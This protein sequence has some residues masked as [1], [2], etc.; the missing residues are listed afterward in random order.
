MNLHTIAATQY[1]QRPKDERFESPAALLAAA[2]HD[3]AYSVERTYNTRDLRV[4]VAR[5]T[6]TDGSP[7]VD[8]LGM[9]APET[10]RLQSPKGSAGFTHWSFGQLCRMLGAPAAYLRS[11][12]PAIAADALNYGLHDRADHATDAKLL[13]KQN[14]GD[15]IVRACTSETYSR[16]WNAELWRP[17]FATVGAGWKTP[18]TWTGEPAGLYQGDR[19]AFAILINGGSIVEDP[20]TRG[21]A[22]GAGGQD[23]GTMYRGIIVRN[24]EVGACSI[25]IDLILFRAICGNHLLWGAS[26]GKRFRRRH[27][28]Q[29]ARRDALRTIL[30]AGRNWSQAGAAA[31]EAIIKQLISAEIAHTREAVID[32]LQ[33]LGAT[34]LQATAAYDACEQ[35]EPA[36]PRSFWGIAQGMTRASQESGY[37][38]ER[39]Q[40]DQLAAAVLARGRKLVAV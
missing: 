9:P 36:S 21:R 10:L 32:E 27:V 12:P 29:H 33:A 3:R 22:T 13:V 23:A 37:Q 35:S 15:P 38:D 16:V 14:G 17:L 7:I 4:G 39:Y 25:V 31:D 19:D 5:A 28:G 30:D 6:G 24:S 26:Y 40:L 8:A 18:P 34:K 1:A 2:E 11:L 20:S